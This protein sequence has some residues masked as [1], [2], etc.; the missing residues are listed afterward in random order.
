MKNKVLSV[1]LCMAVLAVVFILLPTEASAATSGYYT[2]TV[3]DGKATITDMDTSI[4]GNITIPSAIGGY[5][6]TAIGYNAFYSC[7]KITSITIPNS[8]TTIRV[9]A[10]DNCES[11]IGIWVDGNNA[12]Y[13]S[14]NYGVL[15]NKKKTELIRAPEGF[16]GSYSIPNSV[17]TIGG[18]A[19][20]DCSKLT[21]VTISNS[22][23]TIGDYAFQYCSILTSVTIPN[24]VTTIGSGAFEYCNRLEY[25]IY[26]NCGYL[27]N[28]K[29]PYL[30][31]VQA[32][33][34]ITSCEIHPKTKIILDGAFFGCI[35]LTSVT[36]PDGV[37]Q[38]GDS[39]FYNSAISA[40][41][42]PDSVT[43]IGNHAFDSRAN[44]LHVAYTGDQS[45]WQNISMGYDNSELTNNTNIHYNTTLQEVNT[46]REKSVY[47]PV[48]NE[49][50]YLYLLS[51]GRMELDASQYQS[52]HNYGN[53]L[54]DGNNGQ[55]IYVCGATQLI[56]TFD[57]LSCTEENYDY[58]IIKNDDGAYV[59]EESGDLANKVVTIDIDKYTGT[60]WIFID[61]D[62]SVTKYGY[63]F[64]S[65]VAVMGGQ[66]KQINVE[67]TA[68]TCTEKGM[69]DGVVC[70]TCG[71]VFVAQKEIPK[72]EHD[73]SDW[74]VTKQPTLTS[75]GEKQKSCSICGNTIIEAIDMLGAKVSRWNVAIADDLLVNFYMQISESIEST[76]KVRVYVGENGYTF[77]VANLEQ[78][79]DGLYIVQVSAA[80]AQMND[81]IY[82]SVINNADNT[83]TA[84]Y[85]IR[86]YADT[87]LADENYSQYHALLKEMLNYGAAA[88]V[89]FDYES[90]NL[91]NSGITGAG[92]V[93]VPDFVDNAVSVNGNAKGISFYGAS[94]IFRDRIAVRYYFSFEG[95]IN[96]LTFTANGQQYAP[97]LKNGLYYVELADILPQNLDQ[98]IALSVIDAEGNVLSVSYNPMNYIV[99][100]NEKGSTELKNLV[101]AL[102]NYHLT[103]KAI[104]I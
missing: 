82:V 88:Q 9:S 10:F 40:V 44:S 17:T 7:S 101:K 69:T 11:L 72:L 30:V 77:S 56:F 36:I 8:V 16:S 38:I 90:G 58:F 47:C 21:S 94:L 59:Y 32:S 52:S 39:A 12:N 22:V 66:H 74:I 63:A 102:Y 29:Y 15:Y 91:A 37:I 34:N 100:M 65:I 81:F 35:G 43:N 68:P 103:A 20:E 33:G 2:Y 54:T 86:Q 13:S 60:L 73:Y 93:E 87:I 14:D 71:E 76:A 26:D 55:E 75:A 70:E 48:C 83:G 51:N 3:S 80:A 5:P 104:E 41:T 67:G 24:S 53:N 31:L 78:T 95:Q 27:G 46:C 19:F 85:T 49:Y 79:E 18:S 62:D 45:Q 84:V 57:S 89:Y 64:S 92:M 61:S 50:V 6:V 25:N 23:T 1:I 96:N 98:P 28:S 42:I 99:R 4:S 97:Q